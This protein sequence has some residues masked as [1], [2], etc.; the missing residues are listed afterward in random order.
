[1]H[2]DNSP[3]LSLPQL[4]RRV[5]AA[6]EKAGLTQAVLAQKLAFN[7]RQ[8]LTA[9]EAGLRRVTAE[10]L[11]ALM[12]ATGV[13]MDF[14]TDPFRLVGE[15][16]FSYRASGV[17]ETELDQFEERARSWIAAW[18]YLGERKGEKTT[19]L[20]PRLAIREY[21]TFEEAQLAGEAVGRELK[22]GAVPSDNLVSALEEQFGLLVLQV[23]M[24]IGVSGAACQVG[25]GE[26]ILVNCKEAA[27]R[28]N[29]DIA[30]ELF[31][32]L[33]WDALPPERV[34]REN[35]SGY[36]QKRTE[37]LADNFAGAL[38]M[39]A[40]L[41]KPFWERR[42][43]APNIGEWI[44]AAAAHF[45]VSTLALRWRLVALGWM[46]K[47]EAEAVK[48][49]PRSKTVKDTPLAAFSR[50]FLE[51]IAWGIDRGEISARRASEILGVEI[52]ELQGLFSAQGVSVKIG[53]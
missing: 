18:G 8:T 26:V 23:E 4:P 3:L 1:M 41:L 20:R 12:D 14:F 34:D 25:N 16:S 31:H 28:R 35:P 52:G 17:D 48:E 15:G 7:D 9:I 10:E 40:E 22:L 29:F 19:A 33:T 30:H 51:R 21:S 6:R 37:Q 43:F 32:V 49:P 36:K 47:K 42:A 50:R 53:L 11:L 46:T 39:P 38:L 2:G 44:A 5:T 45:G 27:V 24:P 13:D